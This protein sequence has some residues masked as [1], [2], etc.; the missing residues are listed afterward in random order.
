MIIRLAEGVMGLPSP[1]KRG[2][3][4]HYSVMSR[5]SCYRGIRL[6]NGPTFACVAD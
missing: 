4:K 3:Q 5:S 6:S 2:G 1:V